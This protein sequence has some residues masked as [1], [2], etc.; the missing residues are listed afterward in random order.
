[1]SST[2][3]KYNDFANE[4]MGSKGVKEIPEIGE[5]FAAQLHKQGFDQASQVYGQY[6]VMGRN[7]ERF[8]AW[9]AQQ[10]RFMNVRHQRTIFQ[11]FEEQYH[12]FLN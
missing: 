1:M 9:L 5:K 11:V 10:C 3:K 8:N 2:T 4:P 7:E 6:L 12:R